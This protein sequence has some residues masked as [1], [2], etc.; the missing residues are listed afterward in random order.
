[1][2][3]WKS[4]S[5]VL[6]LELVSA[7]LEAA[8]SIMSRAGIALYHVHH[9]DALTAQFFIQRSEYEDL[10]ALCRKRG[11]TLKVLHRYGL[12]YTL[13]RLLHRKA[14]LIGIGVLIFAAFY[15]PTRVLFVR[16][17]G[18]TTIPSAR[19]LS[20]AED[21]GIHFG[22][23]RREVR[24]ERVKNALLDAV[25]QLQWAGV[26]T[27]GCTAVISVRERTA[28][29]KTETEKKVSSIVADRDGYILSCLVTRGTG[30][31]KP[32]QA[33]KKGEVLISGYTDCGICIQ[34]ACAEGEVLAQ[35]QRTLEAVTPAEY[36]S[37]EQAVKTMRSYSLRFGKKRIFFWKDS[38]I[39]D[40]SCDRISREYCLT[41]PG[42][43]R[44]PVS[45]CI[46]TYTR[47]QTTPDEIL[48]QDAFHALNEFAG[49]YLIGQMIGGE[50][51]SRTQVIIRDDLSF[52][53]TGK[54]ICREMIGIVR[55][56]QIGE[57][58]GKASGEDRER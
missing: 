51:Q 34:A 33:V 42:N 44:L 43:F 17:E 11:E 1:M 26:N 55:L 40:A 39:L 24:S 50:I 28:D 22:A 45:L 58:N 52:R 18:N 9:R 57:S 23:S 8:L 49:Q 21:S 2:T 32:G 56:E 37:R 38:G 53:L 36:I 29:V 4:I 47:F 41:L 5:G 35:T 25:P 16:I 27:Q 48:Q 31:V 20:A 15:L 19:I 3:F 46:D 6:E 13:L 12:Y 30:L 10:N 7:E 54:Y 14:L